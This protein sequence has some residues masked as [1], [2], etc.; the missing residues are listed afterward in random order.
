MSE[1]SSSS[2]KHESVKFEIDTTKTTKP[3]LDIKKDDSPI[4]LTKTHSKYNTPRQ[5]GFIFWYNEARKY[6][7]SVSLT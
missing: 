1:S 7:K 3:S 6:L 5:E 4:K 2:R